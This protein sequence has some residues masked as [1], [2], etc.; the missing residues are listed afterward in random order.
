MKNRLIL[1]LFLLVAGAA[2]LIGG[3]TYFFVKKNIDG[4]AEQTKSDVRIELANRFK[5]FDALLMSVEGKIDASIRE[6]MP[7]LS[8]DLLHLDTDLKAIAPDVLRR[9]LKRYGFDDVYIID[10]RGIVVNTTFAKDLN[11]NLKAISDLL[12]DRIASAF[13]SGDVAVD[14][15]GFSTLTGVIRKYAYFNP[16]GCDYIVEISINL[17]DYINKEL[18]PGYAID[19]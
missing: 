17:L 11:L 12:K 1:T 19:L 18:S 3:G 4:L 13:E 16:V 10:R 8:A 7:A 9:H 14:R 2:I 6:A 15:I 5:T